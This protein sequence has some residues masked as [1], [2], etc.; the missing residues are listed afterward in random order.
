[1]MGFDVDS[2]E[3]ILDKFSPVFLTHMPFDASGMIV[4]LDDHRGRKRKVLPADCLGLVFSVDPNKR[5]DEC[6]TVSVWTHVYQP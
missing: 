3:K 1:M 5:I 2:F 4:P 6:I